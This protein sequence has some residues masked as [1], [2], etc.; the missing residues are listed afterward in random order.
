[1]K[2]ISCLLWI[3]ATIYG[4]ASIADTTPNSELKNEKKVDWQRV[5]FEE[6]A[7]CSDSSAYYLFARRGT[8]DNLIIHFLGGG[9]CWDY[10]TCAN[11][12]TPLKAMAMGM[13]HNLKNYYLPDVS[14]QTPRV[15][16]GLFSDAK[17]NPFSDWNLVLIPYCTA[18]L[19]L[20]NT[21]NTY[22]N[23]DGASVEVFHNGKNNVQQALAW[24]YANFKQ[25]KKLVVSGDSA[26]GFSTMIYTEPIHQHYQ[27]SETFQVVDCA[28]MDDKNWAD[29]MQ[30][31]K[32]EVDFDYE[33]ENIVTA[34]LKHR[35]P[36]DVKCLYIGSKYDYV[37]SQFNA[38]LTSADYDST[39]VKD[40][41]AS[42][43]H[44]I[45]ALEAADIDYQYFLTDYKARKHQY[46][47][48]HTFLNWNPSYYK[49]EE[50]GIYLYEWLAQN[51][52]DEKASSVGRDL[53]EK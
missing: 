43:S 37:L 51:I 23:A 52:I 12:L 32:A 39:Y 53:L 45:S 29:L 18:D 1:M 25:P 41:A 22:T 26:G 19:Q 47:T 3:L 48:P 5:S 16:S 46:D 40:W 42:L 17:K 33:G 4:C 20:G 50:S 14:K 9:A 36:E 6:A 28:Y 8:S 44:T 15:L 2:R 35:L 31:W 24:V 38:K 21:K 7:F 11:P 27:A 34:I 13:H 30:T 49:C 10:E